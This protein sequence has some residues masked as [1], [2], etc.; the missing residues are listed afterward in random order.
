MGAFNPSIFQPYWFKSVGILTDEEVDRAKVRLIEPEYAEIE[1]GL[2]TIKAMNKRF[3]VFSNALMLA[4]KVKDFVIYVFRVLHHT[5]LTAMGINREIRYKIMDKTYWHNIGHKLAPKDIWDGQLRN[6][7]MALF[8]LSG[9]RGDGYEG[10]VNLRVE[11]AYEIKPCGIFI[12]VNNHFTFPDHAKTTNFKLA[13]EILD[14]CWDTSLSDID[15]FSENIF[16]SV[17]S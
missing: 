14:K 3:M 13:M 16:N 2:I 1:L 7:G 10:S 12:S 6:P 5:P 8:G 9:E 17:K 15:R 4:D 11:P